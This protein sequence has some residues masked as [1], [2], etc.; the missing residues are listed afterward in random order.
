MEKILNHNWRA[1]SKIAVVLI[2]LA[3]V[4]IGAVAAYFYLYSEPP[5]A[6][7][8]VERLLRV[9]F[10]N[11]PYLDPAVGSDEASTVYLVNVY[12]TLVYPLANGTLV[13]HVA[14]RWDVSPDGLIWTFYLRKDVKF[15]SGR[16][17]TAYDVD[18]S[19]RRLLV[20]NQDHF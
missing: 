4:I 12:D 3:I 10:A 6:A 1:I 15:H 19:L 13:P 16:N 14:E 7:P 18:F 9:S 2:I 20:L 11:V 5:P 17:L 8:P